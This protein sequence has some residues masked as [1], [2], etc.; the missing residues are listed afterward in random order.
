MLALVVATLAG[1]GE[2]S[3]GEGAAPVASTPAPT[4]LTV[5]AS[6]ACR[7]M[8]PVLSQAADL[9]VE[10][11]EYPDGSRSDAP[12]FS[13]VISDIEHVQDVAPAEMRVP[14]EEQ[15][16]ALRELHEALTTGQNRTVDFQ[17]FRSAGYE[18][19][20]QCNEHA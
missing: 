9:V 5:S 16:R 13:R 1:C 6:A 7:E 4:S 17:N 10:F 8:M 15:L 2:A 18:L 12:T 3:T 19:A 14:L 11:S 20:S